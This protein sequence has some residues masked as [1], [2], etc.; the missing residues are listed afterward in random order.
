MKEDY[1]DI[2]D[3]SKSASAAEIKKAYRKKRL[4]ITLT[5][6]RVMQKL[7]RNLKQQRKPTKYWAMNKNAPS[8]TA[9]DMLHLMAAK[10]LV[11][12]A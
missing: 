11:A 6:I 10:A 1:Y 5:K 3:V 9:M 7:K 12:A 8:M 2:L 4:P